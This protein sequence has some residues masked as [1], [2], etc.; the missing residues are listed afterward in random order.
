MVRYDKRIKE[1][2]E[3]RKNMVLISL[4]LLFII[5]GSLVV[6]AS[7]LSYLKSKALDLEDD[8]LYQQDILNEM[9]SRYGLMQNY[10]DIK[11]QDDGSIVNIF[12]DRDEWYRETEDMTFMDK[13]EFTSLFSD[14]TVL[15]FSEREELGTCMGKNGIPRNKKW[16]IFE[17]IANA[18]VNK[19]PYHPAN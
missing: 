16:H 11:L 12:G 2:L 3:V 14:F 13:E 5:S 9:I 4:I 15:E 8:L 18:F 7:E 10:E 6:S 17:C 1:V 19:I